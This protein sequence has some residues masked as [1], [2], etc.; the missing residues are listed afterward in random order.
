MY[1]PFIQGAEM[2]VPRMREDGALK[3]YESVE[4]SRAWSMDKAEKSQFIHDIIKKSPQL[5][6]AV[7][8]MSTLSKEELVNKI[9]S[10]WTELKVCCDSLR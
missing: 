1:Q 6:E 9:K 5:T 2:P 3:R 10:L 8:N 4:D 7:K